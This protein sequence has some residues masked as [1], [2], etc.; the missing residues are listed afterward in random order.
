MVEV[1]QFSRSVRFG[2]YEL[3]LRTAQ[4]KKHGLRVRLQRQ[5]AQLL[6]LLV[7]EPGEVLTREQLRGQL[8][9]DDTFVDFDHGLNNSINR[10]REVLCDSVAKPRFIETIP[11]TGYR[12]IGK[13]EEAEIPS[14]ATSAAAPQPVEL[15]LVAD[16]RASRVVHLGRRIAAVGAILVLTLGMGG[17]IARLPQQPIH[18]LVVLPFENLSGDA[19]QE[20]FADGMT[21]ALITDL[22][23]I[24]SLRVISRTSSMHY[25]GSRKSLPEIAKEL[26]V[27]G[28]LEGSFVRSGNRLR[29]T[30]ELLEAPSDQHLWAESYDR[31]VSNVMQLQDDVAKAVARE[32]AVQLT[33]QEHALLVQVHLVKA[34]A[35]ED[36]LRG[37]YF[38][39]LRTVDGLKKGKEYFERAIQK[40]PDYA[41]AYAGLADSYNLMAY[42]VVGWLAPDISGP[43]ALE[44]ASKAL[45]LDNNLAEAHAALGFTKFR[46]SGDW[47]GAEKEL[48]RAIELDPSYATAYLWLGL[49]LQIVGRDEVGCT[50]FRTAHEL[51]PL[52]P[53]IGQHVAWC[54]F[55]E[56]KYDQAIE[57]ARKDVEL[58]P[59]HV[60]STETLAEMY[61]Q[62]GR[63]SEAVAEYQKAVELSDGEECSR[64]ILAHAQ[65]A[66][67]KRA[68]AEKTL[69]ELKATSMSDPYCLAFAYVGLGRNDDAIRSLEQAF[70]EH[71]SGMKLIDSEW[72]FDPLK[73][74]P[75]FQALVRRAG[76]PR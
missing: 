70:R 36:Y 21:D 1:S 4:L 39:N 66:F 57:E 16:D 45:Q 29:I 12:F 20:Y 63:L 54:L 19:S 72:R 75:R 32:I 74:D 55:G 42:S 52:N 49:Y 25:K 41:P 34:E 11:K 59:R 62:R 9:S 44:A 51:D 35:Y 43:R 76:V 56:G 38:W 64:L 30:T 5:P 17:N 40:D 8:W 3:D 33:P 2:A 7:S 47:A 23:K 37:R 27:D 18:S 50:S 6:V 68:E 69:N 15:P 53:N 73:S 61:E 58:D 31:D 46:F 22:A 24:R 28:V 71:S 13:V 10:I 26:N 48:Q 60:N 67:G 14:I 65:A